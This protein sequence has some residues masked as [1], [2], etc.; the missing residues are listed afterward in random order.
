V[1][2]LL[3]ALGGALGALV[4]AGLGALVHSPWTTLGIN[5]TGCLV[6]GVVLVFL[7][8][9]AAPPWVRPFVVTGVL[10]GYTTYSTFAVDVVVLWSRPLVA[11]AYLLASVVGCLAAVVAGRLLGARLVRR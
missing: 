5:V 7:A 8:R 9:P 1:P 3:A 4:R 11:T 6:I 10:G 2:Y